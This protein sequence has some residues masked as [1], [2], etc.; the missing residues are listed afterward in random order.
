VTGERY[1]LI[2]ADCHAGANHE[3]YREYLEHRYLD[4]FDRWRA[5]YANPF[6]DLQGDGRNRNWDDDRRIAELE[7]DGVVAEVI[8]PNTVPPFFPTGAVVARPPQPDELELRLAGVRAHNR[9]LADW[10]ASHPARRAGIGQIFLN[11]VDEAMADVRFIAEHGLR[12]GALLP[13]VPDDMPHISALYAPDY[14]PVWA[15]CQELGVVLNNHS[16]GSGAPDY[17]TSAAAG[18]VWV[19]EMVFFSRRPLTHMLLGGVFERF[20]ELRFVLTEQG[21][22]WIPPV[23]A[24]LDGFHE[25]MARTGRIGELK[26]G[27][28]DVLPMRPSEYFARNVWVGVSFPSPSEA[29]ARHRIGVERFMWGS[30]YP[31]DEST[32]P[33][34]REG[35]RR[36]FAG[37]DAVELQQLLAGNAAHVY[38]FDLDALRP[39]AERV[40]PTVTELSEPLTELPPGNRSPAFSR[41]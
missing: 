9:W 17:G 6:R 2:S 25:Q 26:Y 29:E 11:D 8:F 31:H 34:T 12:G 33:N 15:L 32:Y 27:P 10:C 37:V 18:A 1:T 30:D 20:P 3:I 4:D 5:A 16:G 21:C 38:G 35:L 40:G 36:A 23:L 19:A 14:D 39:H 13:A 28:D 7:A 24:Q 22:A 41:A